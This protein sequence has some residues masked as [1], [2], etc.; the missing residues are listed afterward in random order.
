MSSASPVTSLYVHVPFCAQKCEYCAFYSEPSKGE[1]IQRYVEALV[2]ELEIVAPDL[3]SNTIFFGGGT[4]SL[5][6]LKQ[7]ETILSCMERLGLLKHKA[8]GSR[9]TAEVDKPD[10]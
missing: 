3:R 8:K 9:L 1:T 10:S 6:N 4:P 7:W 2:R 5:L